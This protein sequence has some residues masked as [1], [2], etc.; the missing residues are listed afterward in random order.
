MVRIARAGQN[1]RVEVIDDGHGGATMNGSGLR[2]L[3]DRVAAIGG[4]FRLDS[5]V[6]HGTRVTA[7][8]PC[9]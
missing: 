3:A 6:G 2:G 8:L 4:H 7:E 5:P 1:V 9:G